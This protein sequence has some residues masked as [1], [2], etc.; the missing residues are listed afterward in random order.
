MNVEKRTALI[1]RGKIIAIFKSEEDDIVDY[2]YENYMYIG[3]SY[4]DVS[5][6]EYRTIYVEL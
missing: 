1:L 6:L 3:L 4:E 2:V 5:D